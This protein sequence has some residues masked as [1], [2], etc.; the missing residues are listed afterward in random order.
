MLSDIGADTF[1][2]RSASGPTDVILAF[3]NERTFRPVLTMRL[4]GACRNRP[5]FI[6]KLLVPFLKIF[7]RYFCAACAIDLSHQTSIGPGL[8]LTHGWGLVVS[9][10]AVIGSNC[11]IFHGVTIGQR[12]RILTDGSRVSGFP[13]IGNDCWI[14]PGSV[15][16]GQIFVG[17]GA[18]IG[19]G[20]VVIRDV[21]AHSAVAGN[22]ARV[23]KEN[24]IADVFNR[25]P[26]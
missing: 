24:I 16:I 26:I 5:T 2:L 7:H 22:P 9:P 15:L 18:V 14:G 11:T 3:L 23:I 20:A 21:P 1:R 19:A 17:D 12:D 6:A 25:A 13:R 8:R 4:I 10:G